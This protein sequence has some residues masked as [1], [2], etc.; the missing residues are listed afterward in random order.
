ILDLALAGGRQTILSFQLDDAEATDSDRRHVLA[1]TQD[2]DVDTQLQRRIV[3]RRRPRE[4]LAGHGVRGISGP[5]DRNFLAIDRDL[6][7]RVLGGVRPLWLPAVV[8]IAGCREERFL[9][10]I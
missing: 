7:G 9:W 1:V 3:D 5:L 2:G 10:A 4:R 8:V 6:G